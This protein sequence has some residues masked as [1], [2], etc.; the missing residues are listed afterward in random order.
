MEDNLYQDN[1]K[2]IMVKMNIMDLYSFCQV[3]K[4]Y[5]AI[6]NSNYFWDIKNN[7]DQTSKNLNQIVNEINNI[8]QQFY[9]YNI[10]ITT[11]ST[12]K[13]NTNHF[14]FYCDQFIRMFSPHI[15]PISD[16]IMRVQ[17]HTNP[18]RLIIQLFDINTRNFIRIGKSGIGESIKINKNQLI[19]ILMYL[20][21]YF[22]LTYQ[23]LPDRI[24]L[25]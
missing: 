16:Y 10:I 22:D 2:D 6:C 15:L 17:I 18:L 9:L 23:I 12:S 24:N 19:D 25:L 13:I 7:Y 20:L 11:G 5:S 1:I 4:K 14:P 3:N 21:Y 8:L